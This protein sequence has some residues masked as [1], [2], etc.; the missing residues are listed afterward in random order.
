M[1]REYVMTRRGEARAAFILALGNM[2]LRDLLRIDGAAADEIRHIIASS[3]ASE[4][5]GAG[6]YP[7]LRAWAEQCINDDLEQTLVEEA[8]K[9]LEA[10]GLDYGRY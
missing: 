10:E 9:V 6:L 1:N 7:H 5:S 2:P 3:I 8:R 4:L